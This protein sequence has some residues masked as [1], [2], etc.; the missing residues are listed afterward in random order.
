MPSRNSKRKRM[1]RN[2]RWYEMRHL[3]YTDGWDSQELAYEFCISVRLVR[4]ILSKKRIP[5]RIT[6]SQALKELLP[7]LNA[8]FGLEYAESGHPQTETN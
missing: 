3:F 5:A 8:L 2:F 4:K 1:E 6:R 7:G